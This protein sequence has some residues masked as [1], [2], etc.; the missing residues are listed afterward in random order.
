M[1]NNDFVE[2]DE[3]KFQVVD[4]HAHSFFNCGNSKSDLDEFP[5]V[6]F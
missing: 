2:A 6:K 5:E 1:L 3:R 4:G